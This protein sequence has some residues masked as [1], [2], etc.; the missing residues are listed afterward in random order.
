MVINQ[1]N[2]T[3]LKQSI[4]GDLKETATLKHIVLQSKER[5]KPLISIQIDQNQWRIK[6]VMDNWIF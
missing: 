6:K 2:S 5:Y 1:N 3:A 4:T